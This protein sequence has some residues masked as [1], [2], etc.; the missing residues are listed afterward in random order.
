MVAA[1]ATLCAAAWCRAYE[2]GD[3]QLWVNLGVNGKIYQELGFKF[4]E[5]TRFGDDMSENYEQ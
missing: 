1:V 4:E 3:S 5:E 2:D